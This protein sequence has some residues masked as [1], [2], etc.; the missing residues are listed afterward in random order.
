MIV[1]ELGAGGRHSLAKSAGLPEP[2]TNK[3][4]WDLSGWEDRLLGRSV[5]KGE[6]IHTST[7]PA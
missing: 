2:T 3:V 5:L 4:D 1:H 7:C 6:K